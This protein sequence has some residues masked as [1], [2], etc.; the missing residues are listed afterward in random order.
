MGQQ[1]QCLENL[2]ISHDQNRPVPKGLRPKYVSAGLCR[3][4]VHW[5]CAAQRALQVR[6]SDRKAVCGGI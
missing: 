3:L 5:Y 1:L 6:I 4:P 2:I